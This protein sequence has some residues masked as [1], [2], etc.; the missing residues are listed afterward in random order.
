MKEAGYI[1]NVVK[2][3]CAFPLVLPGIA[4]AM[5]S[6]ELEV[7]RI[8]TPHE[9]NKIETPIACAGYDSSQLEI[10]KFTHLEAKTNLKLCGFKG[11]TT[12]GVPATGNML[13]RHDAR[14]ARKSRNLF[15]KSADYFDRIKNALTK[16]Y[17]QPAQEEIH[18]D[19]YDELYNQNNGGRRSVKWRLRF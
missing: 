3:I 13:F 14:D 12:A 7:S 6:K 11:S 5:D 8:Y 10:G 19:L 16:E 1:R 4:Y 18:M 15:D 2:L 17:E 9:L